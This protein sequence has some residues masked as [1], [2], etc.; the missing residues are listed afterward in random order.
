MGLLRNN[1]CINT[2]DERFQV[3]VHLRDQGEVI[4]ANRF[5]FRLRPVNCNL[6]G[7]LSRASL[8]VLLVLVHLALLVLVALPGHLTQIGLALELLLSAAHF[9]FTTAELS[10]LADV[11]ASQTGLLNSFLDLTG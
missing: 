3:T 9:R 4:L 5:V 8:D 7:G 6:N 2:S 11:I 1:L 10:L